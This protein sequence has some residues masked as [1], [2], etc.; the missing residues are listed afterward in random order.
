MAEFDLFKNALDA[1][2][3]FTQL[4]RQRAEA[5][6]KEFVR[7]GEVSREQAAERVEELI[8][9]SRKNT[10]FIVALVRQ[11]IDS[12]LAHLATRDDLAKLAARLGVAFPKMAASKKSPAKKSGAKKAPAK[13][14]A[15]K[16]APAKKAAAAKKA[17]A[18]KAPAKKAAAAKKA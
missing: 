6:V 15:A 1:G 3:A 2:V 11:E 9:R 7:N 18:N 12:R 16:K 13:K 17:P 14:A 10:E 4:T 8:D 5:I